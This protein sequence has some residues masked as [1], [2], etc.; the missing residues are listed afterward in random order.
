MSM[1]EDLERWQIATL[2]EV[3]LMTMHFEEEALRQHT[4]QDAL[5]FLDKSKPES[6]DY[7]NWA[8]AKKFNEITDLIF[9]E[10]K[11]DIISEAFS[12][13]IKHD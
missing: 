8:V 13:K 2:S 1:K 3:K 11:E 6:Q 7:G 5:N 12:R 9:N 4:Y 10:A